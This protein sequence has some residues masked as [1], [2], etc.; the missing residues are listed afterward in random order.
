MPIIQGKMDYITELNIKKMLRKVKL[1]LCNVCS[2]GA[3]KLDLI[4]LSYSW[5]WGRRRRLSN[6]EKD[7]IT[8][9]ELNEEL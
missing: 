1:D 2:I 3:W 6:E 5:G 9:K 4:G 8:S 7:P